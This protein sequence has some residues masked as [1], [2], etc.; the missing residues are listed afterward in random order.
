MMYWRF[1]TSA[2]EKS[3]V[4][5][6]MD[7]FFDKISIVFGDRIIRETNSIGIACVFN[8]FLDLAN[9]LK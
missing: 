5:L 9:I 3:R 8:S 6:G 4:P 2:G 7:G 1:T